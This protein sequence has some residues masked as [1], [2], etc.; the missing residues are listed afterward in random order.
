MSLK[1][2]FFKDKDVELWKQSFSEQLPEA[3]YI[4]Y[5][6]LL[7]VKEDGGICIVSGGDGTLH[8][9]V[10]E[11]IASGNT[12]I[13]I[14]YHPAG[15]GNDFS[16]T[17]GLLNKSIPELVRLV[18]EE[19]LQKVSVGELSESYFINMATF[20]AF[21][22]V[23]PSVDK[24]LKG[25]LGRWSYYLQGLSMISELKPISCHFKIND[26][27][28]L[29]ESI[30]GFFIG[31][32]NYSGGGI[33]VTAEASPEDPLLE[34]LIIQDM[35]IGRLVALGLELQKDE[36]DLDQ[37]KVIHRKIKKLTFN[38]ERPIGISLDGESQKLR[39]GTI[40]AVPNK[41]S[42]FYDNQTD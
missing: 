31:N 2:G 25:L 38:A 28:D 15:T 32:A 24:D 36:P 19:K 35:E 18:A 9:A 14:L 6:R 34:L 29:E 23:T 16:R 42:I 8:H 11:I 33:Q 12:N 26:D 27:I 10:N 21:A 39:S 30:I 3:K 13:S 7:S 1:Y 5:E 4:D 37:Y 40:K 20:G 41:I 17:I 22:E